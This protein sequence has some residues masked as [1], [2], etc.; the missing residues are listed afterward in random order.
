[1]GPLP[2]DLKG[3]RVYCVR[4]DQL[5]HPD[6]P[7]D[8]HIHHGASGPGSTTHTHKQCPKRP[9]RPTPGPAN[10]SQPKPDHRP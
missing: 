6:E 2:P 7:Y 4:C 3:T 8:T 1:M 9:R 5:I 10:R